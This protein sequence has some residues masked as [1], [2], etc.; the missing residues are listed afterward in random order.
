LSGSAELNTFTPACVLPPAALKAVRA[1]A[2][3]HRVE[4]R[5]P[6]PAF[7]FAAVLLT[8]L[9]VASQ[10][11][12]SMRTTR[13]GV[14]AARVVRA[15]NQFRVTHG[16]TRLKVSDQL[17]DAAHAHS[18]EMA[19]LGYFSHRSADGSTFWQRVRRWYVM[20]PHWSTGENLVWRRPRIGGMRVLHAWLASPPH[21]AN[22]VDPSWRDV[23]CSAVHSSSAPGVFGHAAVTIV[24]CDFGA[25]S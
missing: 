24:T 23:G 3:N 8:A 21:R 4:R 20:A 17:V 18:L 25:R 11:A 10:A 13:Q 9:V 7:L 12:A 22:L 19:S 2:D 15:I 5:S 1:T 16:L 6:A 14:V